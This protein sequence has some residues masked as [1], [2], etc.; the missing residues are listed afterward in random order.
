MAAFSFSNGY[1]RAIGF[2]AGP[3][4]IRQSEG[5]PT[6]SNHTW[7]VLTHL[8]PAYKLAPGANQ[9]F[10][11]SVSNVQGAAWRIPIIYTGIGTRFDWWVDHAKE[12]LGRPLGGAAWSTNTPEMVGFSNQ[13][14]QRTGASRFAQET[15]RTLSAAGSRR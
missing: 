13:A 6:G 12:A 5:W 2:A 3:V 14:V 1:P 4:E 9:A 7:Y 15:N 11:V 8:G 10:T